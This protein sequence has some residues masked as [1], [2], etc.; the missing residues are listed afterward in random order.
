MINM[1]TPGSSWLLSSMLMLSFVVFSGC[2]GEEA[3]EK[4]V[5]GGD[6]NLAQGGS[7]HAPADNAPKAETKPRE[8]LDWNKLK[9]HFLG[10]ENSPSH[11]FVRGGAQAMRDPF[12][13]QLVKY[14]KTHIPPPTEEEEVVDEGGG[15]ADPIVE[16][17][18]PPQAIALGPTQKFATAEYRVKLISWG[19]SVNK[20]VVEDPDN[21]TFVISEDMKLGNSNGIVTSITR[22][23]VRVKEDNRPQEIELNIAEPIL[24]I[25]EEEGPSERLFTNLGGQ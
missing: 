1:I 10:V 8:N 17:E 18:N 14:A 7:A 24:A 12:E 4:G 11:G 6:P 25:Q 21:N 2:G 13:P 20:A 9:V 16:V 15:L 5:R 23:Q 19:T 3:T 22:F